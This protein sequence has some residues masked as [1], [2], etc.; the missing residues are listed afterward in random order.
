M[1]AILR[2]LE[3]TTRERRE[4]CDGRHRVFAV[5]RGFLYERQEP[6]LHRERVPVEHH[7]RVH[8]RRRR[9]NQ[10]FLLDV[11]QP[12]FVVANR[13]IGSGHGVGR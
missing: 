6:L 11:A 13:W 5:G 2:P 8:Q 4:I 12:G 1:E 9:H 3:E 10:T 7:L